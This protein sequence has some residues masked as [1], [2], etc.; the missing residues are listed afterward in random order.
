MHLK[1]RER[2]RERDDDDDIYENY[3]SFI[4]EI[5]ASFLSICTSFFKYFCCCCCCCCNFHSAIIIFAKNE[6]KI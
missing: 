1:I 4:F 2:E 3:I 6:K 5:K